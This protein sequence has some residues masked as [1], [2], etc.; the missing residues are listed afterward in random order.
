MMEK[1]RSFR[2]LNVWKKGMEIVKDVY[3]TTGAFPRQESYCLTSQM[4]RAAVSVPSNI[5]EGFNRFQNREYTRFL[6]IALGSCAELETQLE[7]ASELEYVSSKRKHE[8]LDKINH[9]SR[10]LTNLIKKTC[11]AV[12]RT[13][14]NKQPDVRN[15]T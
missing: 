8:L 5:A 13:T 3:T 14:S 1:I 4:R 12:N 11:V 6:Y 10:M 9:E 15:E 7:I 2:D